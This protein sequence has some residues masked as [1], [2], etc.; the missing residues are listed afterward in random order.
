MKIKTECGTLNT[1]TLPEQYEPC[2]CAECGER[3]GW[4]DASMTENFIGLCDGCAAIA[5]QGDDIDDDVDEM[6]MHDAVFG[7]NE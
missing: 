5:S 2:F 7:D 6:I 4:M 1:T 3:L